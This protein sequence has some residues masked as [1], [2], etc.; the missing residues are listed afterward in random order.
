MLS[1]PLCAALAASLFTF[2]A[3]QAFDHGIPPAE[4]LRI[5]EHTKF[6]TVRRVSAVPVQP[7][8]ASKLL[9]T[10][11]PLKSFLAERGQPFQS[12]T[13]A[14]MDD[15]RPMRQL[16]FAAISSDSIVL[17]FWHADWPADVGYMSVIQMHG[18]KA[19]EIFFCT[20]DGPANTLNDVRQLLRRGK[21]SVLRVS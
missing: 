10:N 20:L 9:P 4:V 14:W 19:R 8:I 5:L 16:I 12:G 18:A 13:H 6:R 2:Q 3:A 17:C 1:R 15:T 11:R 7:L 21:I